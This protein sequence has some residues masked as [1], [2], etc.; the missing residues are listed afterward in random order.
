M[1]DLPALTQFILCSESEVKINALKEVLQEFSWLSNI[2]VTCKDSQ[3]TS[4]PVQPI[5]TGYICSV[6]RIDHLGKELQT[7]DQ[8]VVAIENEIAVGQDGQKTVCTDVCH[9]TIIRG[10]TKVTAC[11]YGISL[12][13]EYYLMALK[14]SDPEYVNK[15]EGLS[16]TV[17]SL[18]AKMF[19]EIK[20]NNWMADSRF[21]GKDRSDQIKD[22]LRAAIQKIYISQKI[23]LYK[24]YPR[25]GVIYKELFYLCADNLA[26]KYASQIMR[27]ALASKGLIGKINKIMGFD[28]RG[29]IF[30]AMLARELDVGFIMIR[31]KGKLPGKK[32][33]VDYQGECSGGTLELVEDLVG[34]DDRI[35]L[36][37]DVVSTGGTLKAGIDAISMGNK[38]KVVG[39]LTVLHVDIY[40]EKAKTQLAPYE[41]ITLL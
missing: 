17:G 30:G 33:Q 20:A 24:D 18:I 26:F 14:E 19:P 38:G 2:Q 8:L 10:D 7:A 29:F 6:R 35:L 37:D 40:L 31:K 11:S 34:P 3:P 16:I 5:N 41:L 21:G 36:V 15:E 39:C 28:A 32:Y 12:P 4:N 22:A 27:Q 25:E 9:A 1:Q 23:A 13:E